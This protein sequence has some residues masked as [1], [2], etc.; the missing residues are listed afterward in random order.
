MSDSVW[1]QR[2]V[3]KFDTIEGAT[4]PEET[5]KEYK[6]RQI[7]LKTYLR[8]DR[9][10]TKEHQVC[11]SRLRDLI[12]RKLRVVLEP[13]ERYVTDK[14]IESDAR[15]SIEE[16]VDRVIALNLDFLA[17][18]IKAA[19]ITTRRHPHGSNIL[20]VIC[21]HDFFTRFLQLGPQGRITSRSTGA[22]VILIQ[23]SLLHLVLDPN[24]CNT[25]ARQII[26]SQQQV[27][28]TRTKQPIF[29]GRNKD[30]INVTWL[31]HVANFFKFHLKQDNGEGVLAH[32]YE[33]LGEN[34]RPRAWIGKLD[35]D[36]KTRELGKRW[37]GCFSK[38]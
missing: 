30:E 8:F 24:I 17:E 6:S 16:G 35:S 12:L 31:L 19:R 33:A 14:R 26:S 2:A 4:T 27:Y 9:P 21:S 36:C 38:E 23:L 29:S 15:I 20:D 32:S 5:A 1:R 7:M 34:E 3:S 10:N 37:K 22:L 28:Q 18:Y 11:L 25:K 13:F